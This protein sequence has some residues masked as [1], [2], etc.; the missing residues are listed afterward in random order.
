MKG[1]VM[2][3]KGEHALNTPFA[4][5]I[6]QD[7]TPFSIWSVRSCLESLALFG[8]RRIVGVRRGA[9]FRLA[10]LLLMYICGL[11]CSLCAAYEFRFDF[12]VPREYVRQ[13]LMVICWVLPLKL[14]FLLLFR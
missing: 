10:T 14:V 4:S 3:A 13:F 1:A 6:R 8:F 7:D 11:A 12:N 5:G 2:N 9:G